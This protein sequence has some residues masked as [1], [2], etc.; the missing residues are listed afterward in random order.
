MNCFSFYIVLQSSS[1]SDPDEASSTADALDE[2]KI[3]LFQGL[4]TCVSPSIQAVVEFAKRLAGVLR[5]STY[6][7]VSLNKCVICIWW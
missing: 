7:R 4:A 6:P 2:Q 5:L 3:H 1:S